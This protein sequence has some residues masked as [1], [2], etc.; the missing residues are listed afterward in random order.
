MHRKVPVLDNTFRTAGKA[1]I[2]DPKHKR[3][4]MMKGGLLSVI[5]ERNEIVSWVCV[6]LMLSG[7]NA[8]ENYQR[9]CQS[10]SAEETTEILEGY[11]R[12]C[13]E[14][15]ILPPEMVVVDNCCHVRNAVK[16][17]LPKTLIVLDV[18]H[19]LMR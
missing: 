12:R 15:K 16:K 9:L 11:A 5:N 10:G 4:K 18:Y 6:P 8:N 14:L 19:F 13:E 3:V 7:S 1:T 2:V 17:A